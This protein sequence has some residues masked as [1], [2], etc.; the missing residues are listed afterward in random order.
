MIPVV[1]ERITANALKRFFS[2]K[3]LKVINNANLDSDGVKSID[4][5]AIKIHFITAQHVTNENING[6]AKFISVLQQNAT[7]SL[8]SLSDAINNSTK[9]VDESVAK[10]LYPLGRMFH[11]IQDVYAHTNWIDLV[12]QHNNKK[13]IWNENPFSP[14]INGSFKFCNFRIPNELGCSIVSTL[15][16]IFHGIYEKPVSYQKYF[17]EPAAP[18]KMIS[19]FNMNLDTKGTVHDVEFRKKYGIS[20]FKEALKLANKHT[21]AKWLTI[22]QKLNERL[23]NDKAE[24]LFNFLKNWDAPDDFVE[25]RALMTGRKSLEKEVDLFAPEFM[26]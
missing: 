14:N 15:N 13:E 23:G 20:G 2:T 19:H 9:K 8:V 12:R 24:Q 18:G 26:Q 7:D 17:L 25:K 6:T 4:L 21:E 5:H 3:A 11:A 16:K 10:S 22:Q 1:H